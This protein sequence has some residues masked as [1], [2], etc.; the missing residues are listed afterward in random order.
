M[1][2]SATKHKLA[3]WPWIYS[4][5]SVIALVHLVNLTD[6]HDWGGDFSHYIHHAKNLAEGKHYLDTG[7][8]TAPPALFMGPY[9]YSPIFPLM[10]VPVYSL[11]GLD[12]IA[13]KSANILIFCLLLVQ[14]SKLCLLQLNQLQTLPII[15][16]AGFNPYLTYSTNSILPDFTLTFFCY[17]A[18]WLM[19]RIFD[20]EQQLLKVPVL[21]IGLLG[22][23]MY[24]AYG[25]KEVGL[26]LPLALLTYE[27]I[28][29]KRISMISVV[30]ISVFCFLAI[31][32]HQ[33]FKG[34]FIPDY[35]VHSMKALAA[36]E[37]KISL[38][39]SN[40]NFISIDPGRMFER[41]LRYL[42]ALNY[43]Y[44]PSSDTGSLKILPR[45]VL[46]IM[47]ILAVIGFAIQL[48]KK[49]TVLE[50][51]SAGYMVTL[52]LYAGVIGDRYLVPIF[53]LFIYYMM[54]G[55]RQLNLLLTQ[56]WKLI[57]AV[58]ALTLTSVSYAYGNLNY[59]EHDR[60]LGISHPAA[61][62]MFDFI[63]NHTEKQDTIVFEKPRVMALLTQRKS[64]AYPHPRFQAPERM[65]AY[66]NAAEADYYVDVSME[67]NRLIYPI[68]ADSTPPSPGLHEVFRNDYFVVYHYLKQS[69]PN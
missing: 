32:Q 66:L 41:M 56:R 61:T 51:F 50:I 30:S 15:V 29:K 34:S 1:I 27:I 46:C 44:F 36:T 38:N 4:V 33:L 26:I 13:L 25:T 10:L 22:I 69:H 48:I 42:K 58:S 24:L 3:K 14:L 37:Q 18:L 6:G 8:I 39:T 11:F 2:N 23:V 21:M 40:F 28:C 16:L 62:E 5:I 60:I 45:A 35:I 12:L 68:P 59:P 53:P 54:I 49:I 43:Y 64:V 17:L 47:L 63:R 52:L 9:G 19:I 67:P 65:N 57:S 55:Y 20:R 31:V 7:Y